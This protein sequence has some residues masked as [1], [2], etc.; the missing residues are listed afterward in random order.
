MKTF[1]SV[2]AISLNKSLPNG[3]ACKLK[4]VLKNDLI[5]KDA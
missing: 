3:P 4:A 5:K 2:Q 1:Y